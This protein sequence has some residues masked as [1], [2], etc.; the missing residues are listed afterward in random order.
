LKPNNLSNS[1]RYI[2]I[3]LAVACGYF[4]FGYF[5]TLLA[6]PPSHASPV[7]PASGFALAVALV[8]GKR[9]VPGLFIG[10]LLLQ[11]YSFLDFSLPD[12][13]LPSLITGAFSSLGSSLQAFLGAYLINHYCGKQNPLIED[14]KIFTFFV[15]GGFISCL[16]APTFGITTIYFQGFIT[17]DDVP[18]SWLTW[19]I[20]DVIGVI[21]FTPIILSLIAK[22]ATLWKERRKLVSYPLICAFFISC[23]YFSIQSNPRNFPNSIRF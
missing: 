22:S 11:I 1:I 5:G 15:F 17:I 9:I 8:Y 3:N 14:K 4:I 23:W 2:N 19:W 18:I 10:I 16:V 6:T 20:G 12:N 13:I 7:W 21:I